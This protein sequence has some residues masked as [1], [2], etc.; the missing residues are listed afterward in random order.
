MAELAD[1]LAGW[2]FERLQF[3]PTPPIDV[4]ALARLMGIGSITSVRM[5]EDG[6]L[7]QDGAT[8]TIYVRD[9]LPSHR[10]R[11][12]IAHEVGHRLLLH[13]RAP[14]ERH[15]RRLAGDAEERLCD[16][17]AA[18]ILLPKPWVVAEFR[19]APHR[20][21]TVRRLSAMTGTSLSASL[22]RLAEVAC[23]QE[24]LL[25]FRFINNKWRLDAP[26]AV[27][28][29]IHG[30]IRTTTGTSEQLTAVGERTRGDVRTELPLRIRQDELTVPAELSVSA[31]SRRGAPEP[32]S[33]LTSWDPEMRCEFRCS[34]SSANQTDERLSR[35]L[36]SH[37]WPPSTSA[38]TAVAA[39]ESAFAM[40]CP[41]L[42]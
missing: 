17:L 4:E 11:F 1:E 28:Y 40:R 19:V 5:V 25:R 15:R 18:A 21:S 37:A 8:A 10:R 36:C 9:G 23:W 39:S 13:P 29:D 16:D 20:L 3:T 12:T 33:N 35:P 42:S 24:S 34:H 32:S 14:A 27:P 6:R 22:V 26:A 30:Q 7:E 31:L 38:A 41:Y 2:L